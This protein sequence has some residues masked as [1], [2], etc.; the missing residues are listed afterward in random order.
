MTLFLVSHARTGSQLI[1][2]S[3]AQHPALRTAG[4]VLCTDTSGYTPAMRQLVFEYC[5]QEIPE[6]V[7]P[8]N[9]RRYRN[10]D[11]LSLVEKRYDFCK[12]LYHHITPPIFEWLQDKTVLHLVRDN[13][14]A[15][16]L[17]LLAARQHGFLAKPGQDKDQVTRSE[18]K[19]QRL[20]A[21]SQH[22]TEQAAKWADR[23]QVH[24]SDLLHR[25]D[26]T[27]ARIQRSLH[28]HPLPIKQATVKRVQRSPRDL[29]TNADELEAAGYGHWLVSE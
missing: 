26:E 28:V 21:F 15:C 3:L 12:L 11:Y 27:I 17:S 19:V 16:L 9:I 1:Q 2:R 8:A 25:W 13:H 29:V 5:G 6:G 24:Y 20:Q 14:L 23:E 4:E 18:V 10:T 7:G 22:Y